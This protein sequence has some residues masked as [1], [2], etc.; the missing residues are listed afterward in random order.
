MYGATVPPPAVSMSSSLHPSMEYSINSGV[1]MAALPQTFD[2]ANAAVVNSPSGL[3]MMMIAA[4]AGGS[5]HPGA[6]TTALPMAV[7]PQQN[8]TPGGTPA[9]YPQYGA[10]TQAPTPG[11]YSAAQQENLQ[12]LKS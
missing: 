1:P 5:P 11:G 2:Y 9:G 6:A 12:T 8:Y 4:S 10:P 3:D 7:H